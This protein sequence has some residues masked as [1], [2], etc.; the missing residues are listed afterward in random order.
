MRKAETQITDVRPEGKSY[1]VVDIVRG[2]RAWA[3]AKTTLLGASAGMLMASMPNAAAE[4]KL[5]FD[6]PATSYAEQGAASWV[7]GRAIG[8]TATMA[9]SRTLKRPTPNK[10]RAIAAGGAVAAALIVNALTETKWGIKALHLEDALEPNSLRAAMNVTTSALGGATV[11]QEVEM[12]YEL[13]A[14]M[15]AEPAL[16]NEVPPYQVP[17]LP[18]G[19]E[20]QWTQRPASQS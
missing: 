10:V 5:P 4:K 16:P 19:V 17:T 7:A 13:S 11:P 18:A 12:A 8:I 3:A 9:A 15:P 20:E 14:D 2:V 1:A 6:N